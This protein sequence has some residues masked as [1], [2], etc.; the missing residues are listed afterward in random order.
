MT[1]VPGV[2]EFG[3]FRLTSGICGWCNQTGIVVR[4]GPHGFG[5]PLDI[6]IKATIGQG[7]THHKRVYP[8]L[9]GVT[10]GDYAK[11]HRQVAHISDHLLR[12]RVTA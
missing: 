11:F 7:H 10:C 2:D 12:N 9:L 8:I 6:D 5:L 1:S 3:S 4:Y